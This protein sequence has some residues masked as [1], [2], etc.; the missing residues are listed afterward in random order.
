MGSELT[1]NHADDVATAEEF[2]ADMASRT[3]IQ[4]PLTLLEQAIL[5]CLAYGVSDA[6]LAAVMGVTAS[7]LRPRLY[8]LE[9]KL[10]PARVEVI[11]A[12]R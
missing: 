6:T 1:S 2:V 3:D 4:P 10:K 12:H 5:L 7:S 11:N 8:R 9:Q